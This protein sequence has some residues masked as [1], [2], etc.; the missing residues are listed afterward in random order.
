MIYFKYTCHKMDIMKK[1]ALNSRSLTNGSRDKT[2]CR[3]TQFYSFTHEQAC[4]LYYGALWVVVG[5]RQKD[6]EREVVEGGRER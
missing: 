1:Y 3:F 2:V 4:V 6:D 5:E